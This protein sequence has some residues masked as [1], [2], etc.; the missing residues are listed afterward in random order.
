MLGIDILLKDILLQTI[1]NIP[2]VDIKIYLMNLYLV[3]GPSVVLF[4][5]FKLFKNFKIF[6]YSN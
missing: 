4:S 3:L 5:L 2:Q 1:W 6:Y